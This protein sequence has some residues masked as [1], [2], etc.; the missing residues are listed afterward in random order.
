[1]KTLLFQCCFIL[2]SMYTAS[3]QD[4][5][6]WTNNKK[7]PLKEDKNKILIYSTDESSVDGLIQNYRKRDTLA[8]YNSIKIGNE[9][10]VIFSRSE[11]LSIS[12]EKE[13]VDRSVPQATKTLSV[14]LGEEG[15]PYYFTDQVLVS[16]KDDVD[17]ERL[18]SPVKA[19]IKSIDGPNYN[20]YIITVKDISKIF[21]VANRIYESGLAKFSHPNHLA[22]I[23][24][25][26]VPSDPM[27]VNQQYLRNLHFSTYYP[28][29]DKE[30]N[31]L[32]AWDITLGSDAIRVVV[33][34]DG[35][36]DHEDLSGRV[37]AGFSPMT[38]GNGN[39]PSTCIS[40]PNGPTRT[41]HGM[42]CAGIIAASHN[43]LG[44]AGIAPNSRLVPVNIFVGGET[45]LELANGINW[46]WQAANGNADIISNSWGFNTTWPAGAD[47]I[48]S[49]ITNARTQGR[50]RNG[51]AR[52]SVVVFAS[53]NSNNTFSGV[54]F[55]ANVDGVITVGAVNY[56]GSIWDYSS[57]GP[58]M[59]LVAI[60]AG[61][62]S[63]QY[64]GCWRP[65]GNIA[66]IDRME[67]N[68]YAEGNY[69]SFFNGTSAA[70]P[71][72]SGTAALMLS[73][74]PDLTESQI[75][76]FLQQSA[77]DM[78]TAGF[79]NTFGYGLVDI[80]GAV[81]L[82]RNTTTRILGTPYVCRNIAQVYSVSSLP[83][84]ATV[85]WSLPPEISSTFQL[86][87][88]TP[89]ANQLTINN[90]GYY[91][92]NTELTAT[93]TAPGAATQVYRMR[94]QNDNFQSSTVP[95]QQVS[96]T[97]YDVPRPA[98]SGTVTNGIPVWVY[99]GCDVFVTVPWP[100]NRRLIKVG[101]PTIFH[102][103]L[104]DSGRLKFALP[105]GSTG[106]PFHF[107]FEPIAPDNGQC[108]YGF[109]FFATSQ[110]QT[111][112][113]MKYQT[114]STAQ[115]SLTVSIDGGMHFPDSEDLS[116]PHTLLFVDGAK[117][118][119]LEDFHYSVEV[120]DGEGQKVLSGVNKKGVA[121]SYFDIRTLRKG[122]YR[123]SILDPEGKR[124][125]YF[126]KN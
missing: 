23:T 56:N 34:D 94:L 54:T 123:L 65:G 31:V 117:F 102:E 110:S 32:P 51:V 92:V 50:V 115:D 41:G 116:S 20:Y 27:F 124:D 11:G 88:N 40:T 55:P 99:M 43:H 24:Q 28:L 111:L 105:I 100:R 13:F 70:C 35:L 107:M 126:T 16:P 5:Y 36:E 6:C 71:Q 18:L 58:Q 33:I 21:E 119:S 96:C 93:V 2:L 81:T 89:S 75:R 86:Q 78:G 120:Y 59:D 101:M 97:Y 25:H 91:G 98:H 29:G 72:V 17:I 48:V 68:G 42:A 57:R 121:D 87:H 90:L 84:G 14:Y 62:S 66:T 69:A 114:D 76:T 53:G 45:V 77:K 125:M 61:G 74:A 82:A 22:Q 104:H 46:A 9:W 12:A 37:L 83:A 118:Y 95:W 73:V 106:V 64:L 49:A 19:D 52:G 109:L 7:Y 15:E 79:D 8:I 1:M 44:I 103:Y 113:M 67:E 30:A 4:Q 26:Y 60:S 122:K 10:A 80:Y 108:T 112:S 38:S 3:G 85:T 39:I 47:I 63:V